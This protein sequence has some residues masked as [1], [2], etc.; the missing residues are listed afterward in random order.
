MH[1]RLTLKSTRP[2][3]PAADPPNWPAQAPGSPPQTLQ[4]RF[5][6]GLLNQTVTVYLISGIKLTGKLR[7]HD[8][9]TLLLRERLQVRA[10]KNASTPEESADMK[11]SPRLE[12]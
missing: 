7:Q 9:Y 12:K 8:Q 11:L 5:L 10:Q 6:T 4:T 1:D 2:R 3:D